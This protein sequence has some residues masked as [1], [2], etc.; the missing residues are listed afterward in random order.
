MPNHA[1][2]DSRVP[3]PE[4]ITLQQSGEDLVIRFERTGMGCLNGFL[5]FWLVCWTGG[6]IFLLLQ[7]LAGGVMD[8]GEAVPLWIVVAFWSAEIIMATYLVYVLFCEKVF[9]VGEQNLVIETNVLGYKRSR[10]IPK[11]AIKRLIQEKDGGEGDDSFPSWGLKIEADKK[12]TLV[13][14]QPYEKSHWVGRVL[15]AWA[16]VEFAKAPEEECPDFRVVA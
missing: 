11:N 1:K 13:F 15:A 6:C 16:N 3:I 12:V 8:D 4:G 10:S 9:R 14:R 2:G 5:I 7:Y